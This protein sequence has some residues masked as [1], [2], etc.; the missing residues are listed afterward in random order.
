MSK[1]GGEKCGK[2][3]DRD[4]DGRTGRRV[5]LT[6]TRTDGHH[7]TIIR[8]VCRRAY[9][10]SVSCLFTNRNALFYFWIYHDCIILSKIYFYLHSEILSVYKNTGMSDSLLPAYTERTHFPQISIYFS[11]SHVH[12]MTPVHHIGSPK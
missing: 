6:E 3:A 10:N 5:G 12:P 7:R 11:Q 1:H 9:K 8:P 4:P 2:R